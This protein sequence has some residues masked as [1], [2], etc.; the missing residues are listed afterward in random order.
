MVWPTIHAA[1]SLA[2]RAEMQAELGGQDDVVASAFEDTTEQLLVGMIAVYL[3]RIEEGAAKLDGAL[4]G[5]YR[6][7]F[8]GWAI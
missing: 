8:V 3:G 2:I 4:D 1:Q 5:D 6:L 7:G